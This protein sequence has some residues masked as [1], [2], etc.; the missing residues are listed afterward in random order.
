MMWQRLLRSAFLLSIFGSGCLHAQDL[1][2]LGLAH[3]GI[4]VSDIDKA[5]LFYHDVLGLDMGFDLI[6]P[7]LTL[8]LQYYKVNDRQYLE[9]YPTLAP[10]SIVRET[11]IAFYTE[12]IEKLHQ[13]LESRGLNP[14]PLKTSHWDG[15][16]SFDL[17]PAPGQDIVFMEFVQYMPASLHT[18]NFGKALATRRISTHMKGAGVLVKDPEVA[19]SLY[20]KMGFKEIW[21]GTSENGQTKMIDMQLPGASGDFVELVERSTK[22]NAQQAGRAGHVILEVSDIKAAHEAARNRSGIGL[23]TPVR[24]PGKG[25]SFDVF[26]PDGTMVTFEQ[27]E[28]S[29]LK[30]AIH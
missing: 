28:A 15:N 22:A 26:D 21:R 16:Q 30:A 10:D 3:M 11:H 5:R 2:L 8:F 1:P 7:D 6:K 12:D 19:E 18:N 20:K 14:T 29:A 27:P 17:R 24:T 25:W 13:L 4:A 9:V 23:T